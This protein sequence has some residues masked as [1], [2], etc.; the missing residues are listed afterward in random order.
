MTPDRAAYKKAGLGVRL[1]LCLGFILVVLVLEDC[2]AELVQVLVESETLVKSDPTVVAL[3]FIE[4][5][6]GRLLHLF[7]VGQFVAVDATVL[8]A[9][10]DAVVLGSASSLQSASSYNTVV[11]SDVWV[12]LL[13]S[14]EVCLLRYSDFTALR[15]PPT[16]K[17][18]LSC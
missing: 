3:R 2:P 13:I 9:V 14:F 12:H 5:A 17:S 6:N 4:L 1:F 7:E 15:S 16:P 8:N 10:S 18:L 11:C